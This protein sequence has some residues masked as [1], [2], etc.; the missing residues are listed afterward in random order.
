MLTGFHSLQI[1]QLK[2]EGRAWA[3]EQATAASR[4]G[5][6]AAELIAE[7]EAEQAEA[8]KQPTRR[9]R[10]KAAKGCKTCGPGSS[11]SYEAATRGAASISAAG[12]HC[13]AAA[14]PPAEQRLPCLQ[15][16]DMQRRR[17][18]PGLGSYWPGLWLGPV[19]APAVSPGPAS[20]APPMGLAH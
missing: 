12:P 18:W 3:D 15:P 2:S 10:K 17:R 16:H 14:I 4:A 6:M 13:A 7:M 8:I 20:A 19:L 11:Q 9:Q 1:M 5:T